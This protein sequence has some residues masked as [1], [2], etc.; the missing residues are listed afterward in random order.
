MLQDIT[1]L[2]VQATREEIPATELELRDLRWIT[3]SPYFT[4]YTT[5]EV[6]TPQPEHATYRRGG[7]HNT[8]LGTVMIDSGTT[9]GEPYNGQLSSVNQPNAS[10][11]SRV[12]ISGNNACVWSTRQAT[13]YTQTNDE[14]KGREMTN[15]MVCFVSKY[16]VVSEKL[17]VY[18]KLIGFE[19]KCKY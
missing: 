7:M 1:P 18:T 16:Q 5:P 12:F 14:E 11:Q 13:I 19:R 17:R 3:S 8:W 6:C 2:R 4:T 9:L 10:T 15:C